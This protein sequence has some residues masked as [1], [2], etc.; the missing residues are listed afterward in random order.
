MGLFP[1]PGSRPEPHHLLASAR[2]GDAAARDAL[3]RAHTRVAL[4]VAGMVSGR[5]VKVGSDDEASVALMAL[6][7]AIDAFDPDQGVEFASFV[8]TVVRRRLIDHFRRESRRRELP[9]S[10]LDRTDDEGNIASPIQVLAVDNHHRR[11]EQEERRAEIEAYGR[12]LENYGI[13]MRELVK[14]S[15]RHQDARARAMDIARTIARDP[16]MCRY[17]RDRRELPLRLL[18]ERVAVSRKTL[19]RQRKYLIAMTLVLTGD[20]GYL[21]E[22]LRLPSERE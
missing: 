3:I 12:E 2:A 19:E 13:S 7:E 17:L 9:M 10:Q 8:T 16:Q 6:N 18:E 4:R 15:P 21:R 11:L 5:Y 1:K 22:Y 20:Y 14:V